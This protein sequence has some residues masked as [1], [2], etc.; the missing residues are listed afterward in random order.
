MKKVLIWSVCL[1]ILVPLVFLNIGCGATEEAVTSVV[2]EAEEETESAVEEVTEEVTKEPQT[3]IISTTYDCEHVDPHAYYDME[4]FLVQEEVYEGLI[5]YAWDSTDIVGVLAES[6]EIDPDFT[7]FTFHL[8]EGVTFHDGTQFNAD[9]VLINYERQKELNEGPAWMLCFV[10]S[11]EKIDDYT[12]KINTVESSPNFLH[13]LAGSWC[14]LKM[15]SPTAI[16]DNEVDGDY[17][18]AWLRENEV[19]TGPYML[20][21]WT[22]DQQYVLVKNDDYWK[23][24]EDSPNNIEKV[25][26]KIVTEPNTQRLLLEKGDIDIVFGH[27]SNEA[28]SDLEQ[29]DEVTVKSFPGS[30]IYLIWLN[31]QQEQLSD[32]KVRQALSYALNYDVIINDIYGLGGRRLLG[33]ITEA[34]AGT[35]PDLPIYT[36]D[37]DLSST[38]FLTKI[39]VLYQYLKASLI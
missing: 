21:E 19:G 37:L 11:V 10:D 27:L 16:K 6:W 23:G 9:A 31:A 29:N 4:T 24:W 13:Y 22:R 33:V 1:I 20:D 38:L 3:L 17:A 2:E 12:V 18:Q 14:I 39:L 34:F 32:K 8:R 15:I 36:Y 26:L 5:A 35:G 30:S 25:I 28:Y 7:E